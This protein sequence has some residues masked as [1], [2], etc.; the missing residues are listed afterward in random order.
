MLVRILRLAA[1]R[2][3][4]AL[5]FVLLLIGT[6]IGGAVY[7]ASDQCSKPDAAELVEVDVNPRLI[8]GRVWFDKYPEKATDEIDIWIFLGGGIGI[9]E[10]GSRYKAEFEIFELERQGSK[11]DITYLHNNK[12]ASATFK[13]EQ[14]EEKR[15]FNA[16]LTLNGL[17]GGTVKLY[18][19]LYDDEMDAAIPWG[20][21]RMEAAKALLAAPR[22]RE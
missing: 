22:D 10:K 20:K 4:G 15:P 12:K 13:V 14:C 18:G 11:L 16:C 3:L 6:T 2:P 17:P 7:L 8:L 9:H 19:F 21:S 1:R 5:A